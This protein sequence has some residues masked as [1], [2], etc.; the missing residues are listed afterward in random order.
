MK[1]VRSVIACALHY[2]QAYL[3]QQNSALCC[4]VKFVLA[5]SLCDFKGKLIIKSHKFN[6]PGS[7]YRQIESACPKMRFWATTLIYLSIPYIGKLGQVIL[8]TFNF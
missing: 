6:L 7:R 2:A 5:L 4:F 1:T 8:L 3:G